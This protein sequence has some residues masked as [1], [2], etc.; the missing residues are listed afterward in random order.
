MT[1]FA[2]GTIQDVICVICAICGRLS[3]RPSASSAA[4]LSAALGGV[5]AYRDAKA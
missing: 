1:G 4:L 2:F 3:R 5:L